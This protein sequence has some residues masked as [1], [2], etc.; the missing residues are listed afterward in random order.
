MIPASR[1]LKTPCEK[2]L[3]A[4]NKPRCSRGIFLHGLSWSVF[5]LFTRDTV[6]FRSFGHTGLNRS[7]SLFGAKPKWTKPVVSTIQACAE[8]STRMMKLK[9][10]TSF[11]S[12]NFQLELFRE[13]QLLTSDYLRQRA[14]YALQDLVTRFLTEDSVS[15][16]GAVLPQAVRL[17]SVV[18]DVSAASLTLL[19]DLSH[20]C[21][22]TIFSHFAF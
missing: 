6:P 17:R 16:E 7:P 2:N 1:C 21:V 22:W 20:N 19:F 8:R 5:S 3:F 4:E 12:L 9:K 15:R 11:V 10:K 18:L 13:L 14:L